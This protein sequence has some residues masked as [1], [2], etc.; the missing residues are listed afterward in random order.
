ML[1]GMCFAIGFVL[2]LIALQ[3]VAAM[4]NAYLDQKQWSKK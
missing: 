3:V 1:S 4:V 2:A